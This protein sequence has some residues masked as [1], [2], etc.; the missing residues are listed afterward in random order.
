MIPI[1]SFHIELLKITSNFW[2]QNVLWVWNLCY[3]VNVPRNGDTVSVIGTV[4][5]MKLFPCRES[6]FGA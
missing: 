2:M 4:E 5:L 3:L 6:I 1:L